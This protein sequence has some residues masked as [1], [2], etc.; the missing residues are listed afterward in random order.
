MSQKWQI[1]ERAFALLKGRF[2]RFKFLDMSRLK[3][4][5]SFIMASCVLHNICL[6]GIDDNVDD[7]IEEGREP[8][9]EEENY[10]DEAENNEQ[11]N[12]ANGELKQNYLCMRLAETLARRH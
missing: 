1:I 2:R 11:R 9:E 4:I 5:P 6:E 7:F 8:Q 12:I 3:S 10:E